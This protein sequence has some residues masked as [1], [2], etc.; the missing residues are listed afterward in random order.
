M[1]P[2]AEAARRHGLLLWEDCALVFT[3]LQG[4]LGHPGSDAVFFSFGVIKRATALGG[5]VVRIE[6][7]AILSGGCPYSRVVASR[8]E[9]TLLD[10]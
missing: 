8:Q 7:T 5:G 10:I 9:L 1:T 3:G 4:Y 6:D 2:I